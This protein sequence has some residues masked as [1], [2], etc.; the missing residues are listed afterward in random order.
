MAG[1]NPKLATIARNLPRIAAQHGVEVRVTSG[2]RSRAKQAQLYKDYIEGRSIYPA[3][4]PGQSMHEKGLALDI[5]STNTQWLVSALQ[6]VG[7]TWA[8]TDDPIHF[9]IG[10]N[11]ALGSTQTKKVEPA[12]EKGGSFVKNALGVVSWVP[13]PVGW[14]AT[15]LD[16]LW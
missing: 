9:Q 14:A 1:L 11:K 5:L 13:G 2:Y 6:G 15:V 10:Q 12:K 3:N 4:P 16:L 8:G 7:L